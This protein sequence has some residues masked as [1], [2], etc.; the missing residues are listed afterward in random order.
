MAQKDPASGGVYAGGYWIIPG[1]GTE[2]GETIEQ[3]LRREILE[4]VGLDVSAYKVTRTDT[5]TPRSAVKTLPT[6]EHINVEMTF[7]NFMIE[8]GLPAAEVPVH[9]T[10]ELPILKWV[11]PRDLPKYRL[12]PPSIEYFTKLGILQ[13]Y[14]ID[15]ATGQS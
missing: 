6:G 7:F 10:E 12:T 1:G 8:T 9:P 4:E 13:N 2:P 3:A 15:T 11:H 14:K 5:V